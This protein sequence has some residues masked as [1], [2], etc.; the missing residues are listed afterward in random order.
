MWEEADYKNQK[1]GGL[2]LQK[3]RSRNIFQVLHLSKIPCGKK[4]LRVLIFAIFS[5]I[6]KNMFSQ[7]KITP[8]ILPSKIYSRVNIL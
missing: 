4:F 7:T 3:L 5:A 8:N 2:F 6:R 1:T